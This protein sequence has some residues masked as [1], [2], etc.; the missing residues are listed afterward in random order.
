MREFSA[1]HDDVFDE[2]VVLRDPDD[3]GDDDETIDQ[4]LRLVADRHRELGVLIGKR[5]FSP[6][7]AELRQSP[8]GRDLRLLAGA[9]GGD[10]SPAE[11]DAAA[12]RLRDVL[13]RPIAS[14]EAPAPAWFWGTAI[15]RMT[16][17]AERN[18]RGASA[19]MSL[20]EAA[21][22]LD[23]DRSTLQGWIADGALPAIPDEQGQPLIPCSAI[24]RRRL[25]R[26]EFS[27]DDL[28]RPDDVVL[29]E[30]RLAS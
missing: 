24:E 15:G 23:V 25:I 3:A 11:V 1:N 8:L 20:P 14:D 22:R 5:A 2:P 21:A 26:L 4:V 18:A 9:A 16:A 19:F 27:I 13:L 17:R 6:T 29:T 30:R 7:L 10:A 28:A 12:T